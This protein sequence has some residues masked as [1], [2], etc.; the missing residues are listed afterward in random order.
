MK[1]RFDDKEIAEVECRAAVIL[2]HHDFMQF[3]AGANANRLDLAVRQKGAGEIDDL[4]AGQFGHEYFATGHP[5][6]IV[7][8][9]LHALV[10]GDPE[11]R[12]AFVSNR[13]RRLS[14][15]D[16]ALVER[17]YAAAR[18]EY[19]PVTYDREPRA[20]L[21]AHVIGGDEDLVGGKLRRAIEIDRVGRLVGRQGDDPL[22]ARP[23]CGIHDILGAVNVRPHAFE[24]IVFRGRHLFHRRRMDHEFN[25]AHCRFEPLGVADI[26][27]KIAQLRIPGCRELLFHLELFELVARENDQPPRFEICKHVADETAPE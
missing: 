5:R 21:T 22:D 16:H 25:I 12:H 15:G 19:V 8:H 9:E 6:Q 11:T 4:H 13:K 1:C 20:A 7:Q 18:S 2:G 3:F 10:D 24:R 26:A 23:D 17:H 27:D 14:F